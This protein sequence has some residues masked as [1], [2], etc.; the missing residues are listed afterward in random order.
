MWSDYG[1]DRELV[2]LNLP[3]LG[4]DSDLLEVLYQKKR[5]RIVKG[6]ALKISS[7]CKSYMSRCVVKII[8]LKY[9]EIAK[10]WTCWE[11]VKA[12]IFHRW[13]VGRM[14]Q[15]F[16]KLTLSI[17]IIY[18]IDLDLSL[19]CHVQVRII[20]RFLG[21][22]AIARRH[23]PMVRL[24]PTQCCLLVTPPVVIKVG[25]MCSHTQCLIQFHSCAS[26]SWICLPYYMI[27]IEI[28]KDFRHIHK[29]KQSL[30]TQAAYAICI[31]FHSLSHVTPCRDFSTSCFRR[32]VK[33][34]DIATNDQG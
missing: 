19:D 13:G 24:G 9:R 2:H 28:P 10:N 5:H 23:Y 8:D 32:A 11:T 15:W 16:H 29:M 26:Y 20:W 18:I 21:F 33:I 7:V 30:P 25:R 14:I 3:S 4:P 12:G 27:P 6:A 22:H 34:K 17:F 31:H 1:S